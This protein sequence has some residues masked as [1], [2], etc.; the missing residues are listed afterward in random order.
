MFG[1][2]DI[3][4]FKV[5]SFPEYVGPTWTAIASEALLKEKPGSLVS[6]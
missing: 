6:V 2:F 4:L 3:E 1:T 5:L